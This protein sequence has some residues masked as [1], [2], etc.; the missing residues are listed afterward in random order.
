MPR[1]FIKR[2]GKEYS[3]AHCHRFPWGGVSEETSPSDPDDDNSPPILRMEFMPISLLL[4]FPDSAQL[5]DLFMWMYNNHPRFDPE[6][7]CDEGNKHWSV[8]SFY[9]K[10]DEC[11]SLRAWVGDTFI[12]SIWPELLKESCKI[13]EE[14]IMASIAHSPSGSFND[15]FVERARS[16]LCGDPAELSFVLNK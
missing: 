3:F 1:T 5:E 12:P 16:Q 13:V 11:D 4:L 10:P 15:L 8:I 6:F 9:S 2:L 7:E 14:K